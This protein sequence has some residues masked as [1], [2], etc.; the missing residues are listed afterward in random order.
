MTNCKKGNIFYVLLQGI[1]FLELSQSMLWIT[2]HFWDGHL[3]WISAGAERHWKQP[4]LKQKQSVIHMFRSKCKRFSFHHQIPAELFSALQV[5]CTCLWLFPLR[6]NFVKVDLTGSWTM[7]EWGASQPPADVFQVNLILLEMESQ[8]SK[9]W[10]HNGITVYLELQWL[11]GWIQSF[12]PNVHLLG[13]GIHPMQLRPKSLHDTETSE[14]V[15]A[16][17]W[18]T[19]GEEGENTCPVV[20]STAFRISPD[21]PHPPCW[22]RVRSNVSSALRSLGFFSHVLSV[23]ERNCWPWV[24]CSHQ[25]TGAFEQHVS[26]WEINCL[27]LVT[28][29]WF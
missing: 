29:E 26:I 2:K 21:H 14:D 18:A 4:S 15:G 3:C 12:I 9:A 6:G 23:Q 11:W 19:Q 20:H 16:W 1:C 7:P 27:S 25:L 28:F 10:E 24:H 8:N 5:S 13:S 17:R 22:Q